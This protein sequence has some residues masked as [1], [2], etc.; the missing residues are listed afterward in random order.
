MRRYSMV[1]SKTV[2]KEMYT[3][4]L[5]NAKTPSKLPTLETLNISQT[6][7]KVALRAQEITICNLHVP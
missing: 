6:F 2:S 1:N 7:T 5:M 3:S 4:N